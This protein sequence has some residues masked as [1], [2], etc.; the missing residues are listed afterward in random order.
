M[1]GKGRKTLLALILAVAVTASG[2]TPVLAEEQTVTGSEYTETGDSLQEEEP[3]YKEGWNT[4]GNKKYFVKDG[5]IQTKW[6]TYKNHKYYLDPKDGGAMVTGLKKIGSSQYFFLSDGKLVTSRYGYKIKNKYYSV[7]S[8]G[9][10]KALSDVE[11]MAGAR[12]DKLGGM[13]LSKTA[14]LTK[15][16]KWASQI[17]YRA[18]AKVPSGQKPTVYYGEIAFTKA[19]GDCNVQASAFYW[20]AK[21]MGYKVSFVKGYVMQKGGVLGSHAWCEIVSGSRT[22]AYDTDPKLVEL[23]GK[24]FKITYGEKGTYQYYDKNKKKITKK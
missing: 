6:L 16:F 10:L 24:G 19:Q 4:I 15:A 20:M 13:S 12:L 14:L 17:R 2:I 18:V 5:K 21:R 11:G 9:V 1:A 3:A 23:K 7:S 22:Y 8:K